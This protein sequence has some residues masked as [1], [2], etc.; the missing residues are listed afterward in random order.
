MDSSLSHLV[1]TR[2]SVINPTVQSRN[3]R[4]FDE[5]RVAVDRLDLGRGP[6][7]GGPAESGRSAS[8][9]AASPGL[10]TE[11]RRLQVREGRRIRPDRRRPAMR[12][13]REP[14]GPTTTCGGGCCEH[15]FDSL[16]ELACRGDRRG[17][18]HISR[19]ASSAPR[20]ALR[21][22]LGY[23][24]WTNPASNG[25]GPVSPEFSLR[26]PIS[27]SMEARITNLCNT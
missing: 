3:S 6:L 16:S 21:P 11:G 18:A 20:Q 14:E 15:R 22:R 2:Y 10:G 23:P 26:F 27:R 19:C 4:I 12:D 7:N 8:P 17:R 1:L 13:R 25:T 24:T 9:S 5:N